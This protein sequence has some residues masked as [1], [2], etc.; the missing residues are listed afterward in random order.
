MII[1]ISKKPKKSKKQ[2]FIWYDPFFQEN[3]TLEC[4]GYTVKTKYAPYC[5]VNNKPV[6]IDKAI[7]IFKKHNNIDYNDSYILQIMKKYNLVYYGYIQEPDLIL[8]KE[9]NN[10]TNKDSMKLCNT[11]DSLEINYDI[12][13]QTSEG[14]TVEIEENTK[15]F[16]ENI[17]EE[18]FQSISKEYEYKEK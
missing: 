17:I 11:L 3:T 1:F 16:D 10:I 4:E 12:L 18:F 15:D 9:E 6:K 2:K 7:D 8:P 14:I 13:R 5:I